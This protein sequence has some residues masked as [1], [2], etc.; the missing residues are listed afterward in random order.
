[1]I[2]VRVD[3]D[4]FEIPDGTR[5]ATDEHNNLCVFTGRQGDRLTHV[6]NG[7]QQV[8]VADDAS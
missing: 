7:W 6:F 8:E 2:V 5:F 1:M 3:S 4:L